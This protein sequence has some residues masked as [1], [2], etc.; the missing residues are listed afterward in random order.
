MRKIIIFLIVISSILVGCSLGNTPTSKVEDM[1][2]KY[3][4]ND[5]SI[6]VSYYDI[7]DVDNISDD[8]AQK[9]KNIIEKQYKNLVYEIKDEEVDGDKAVVKT[10]IKVKD[11]KSVISKYDINNYSESEYVSLIIDDLEKVTDTI[12][13]T[14]EFSLTKND[15]GKWEVDDL[16]S[17]ENDKLLGIY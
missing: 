3:Q 6:V 8:I 15:S 2:S 7:I 16:T 11:Y 5:D 14:I 4:T 9:Y 1:L 13:Y 10:E 12:V 17:E